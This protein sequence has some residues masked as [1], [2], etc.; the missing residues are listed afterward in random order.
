M[1][2]LAVTEARPIYSWITRRSALH[3]VVYIDTDRRY[4]HKDLNKHE[5]TLDV[6]CV[7]VCVCV[8]CA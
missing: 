3:I 2:S 7:C 8:V 6:V 1:P 4:I 5:K